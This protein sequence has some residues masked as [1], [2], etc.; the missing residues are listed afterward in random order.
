MSMHK[1]PLFRNIDIEQLLQDCDCTDIS[2]EMIA[3]YNER[4]AAKKKYQSEYRKAH[5]E[6]YNDLSRKYYAKHIEENRE[7]A[8]KRY[9]EKR[10]IS[11]ENVPSRKVYT[12]EERHAANIE[13]NRRYRDKHRDEL[14]RKARD[15]YDARKYNPEFIAHRRA[16]ER[17][18]YAAKKAVATSLQ[19]TTDE[20]QC[21]TD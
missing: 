4:R 13:R 17:A 2:A 7:R 12:P 10:A 6:R 15:Y 1:S 16:L 8:R 14:Q 11:I 5:R 3:A 20:E 19:T 9:Y 18:R 21:K